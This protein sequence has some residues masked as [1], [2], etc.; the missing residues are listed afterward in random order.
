MPFSLGFWA[1]AGAGGAAAGTDM[2]LIS[3]TLLTGDTSSVTFS[4]IVGTY[5]HLQIRMVT[6]TNEGSATYSDSGL[7]E[8]NS[9]T[10]NG[11][12]AGHFLTS[13]GG[14]PSSGTTAFKIGTL[15]NLATAL[16]TGSAFA[17]HIIDIPDYAAST[18]YKT[19]RVLSGMHNNTYSSYGNSL[20]SILW[21]NT[22]AITSVTLKPNSGVSWSGGSRFSL[23]G[24]KG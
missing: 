13:S 9:D 12:Y 11:N 8:F 5:K 22:A 18:K 6:R 3:T 16:N 15:R 17:A 23:Y 14:T 2:E 20:T 7:M 21:M 24:I 1:A 10:T 4:S 19:G